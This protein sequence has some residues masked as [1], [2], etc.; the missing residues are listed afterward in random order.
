[1]LLS[2]GSFLLGYDGPSMCEFRTQRG[3]FYGYQE[4]Y[5]DEIFRLAHPD[6]LHRS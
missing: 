4:G 3:F 5:L 6:D 2:A 1:M